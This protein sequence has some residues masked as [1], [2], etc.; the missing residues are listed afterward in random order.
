MKP[1]QEMIML[2]SLNP[3][4][5]GYPWPKRMEVG[6]WCL[7]PGSKPTGAMLEYALTRGNDVLFSDRQPFDDMLREPVTWGNIR[8]TFIIPEL[9]DTNLR[10]TVF[11]RNPEHALLYADDLSLRY[12]YNWN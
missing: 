12:R 11:L 8:K 6:I 4:E 1:V 7:K 9:F 3:V 5:L 2:Y 10:I